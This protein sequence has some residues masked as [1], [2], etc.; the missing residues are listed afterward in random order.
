MINPSKEPHAIPCCTWGWG[1]P[2]NRSLGRACW[3][4]IVLIWRKNNSQG[5]PTRIIMQ[6]P[7][8][9]W[10]KPIFV[11]SPYSFFWV[12]TVV[13][14]GGGEGGGYP[15]SPAELL[16]DGSKA[17]KP[18]LSLSQHVIFLDFGYNP[19]A[20][21]LLR[22]ESREAVPCPAAPFLLQNKAAMLYNYTRKS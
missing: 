21:T 9:T 16:P 1:W 12:I 15:G 4:E 11:F 5:G 17:M 10:A 13:G 3:K 6:R 14:R 19:V 20:V 8:V 22:Q 2:E 7:F 18:Y